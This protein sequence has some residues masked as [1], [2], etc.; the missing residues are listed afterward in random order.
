VHVFVDG[1]GADGKCFTR[2]IIANT[3][4]TGAGEMTL[5]LDD[6][7]PVALVADTAYAECISSPYRNLQQG[8]T[9]GKAVVGIPTCYATVGQYLWLQTKGP[10]WVSPQAAL[11]VGVALEAVF[12]HDGSFDAHQYDDAYATTAQHAGYVL[13]ETLTG[14]QGAPFVK[15]N[16]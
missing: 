9:S 5:T 3:V 12:R 15:L 6:P 11:G 13:A 4:T 8:A 1:S 16:I 14:T 7:I 2:G 10:M